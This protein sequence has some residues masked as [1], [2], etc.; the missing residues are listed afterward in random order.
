MASAGRYAG[1]A[2]TPMVPAS[3]IAENFYPH[4]PVEDSIEAYR[5]AE[6]LAVAMVKASNKISWRH[7]AF[8]VPL[9]TLQAE[10]VDEVVASN[11]FFRYI[12]IVGCARSLPP[13]GFLLP[14]FGMRNVSSDD[15]RLFDY[16]FVNS[17][18]WMFSGNVTNMLYRLDERSEVKR[19]E[20]EG[21]T[22][23]ESRAVTVSIVVNHR[24]GI[25]HFAPLLAGTVETWFKSPATGK[26]FGS[27]PASRRVLVVYHMGDCVAT[28]QKGRD[29][30]R[31]LLKRVHGA[32]FL[33]VDRDGKF[34]DPDPDVLGPHVYVITIYEAQD[35]RR[36]EMPMVMDN[37]IQTDAVFR[38]LYSIVPRE[39][40]QLDLVLA[41]LEGYRAMGTEGDIWSV[42]EAG[43]PELVREFAGT[44]GPLPILGRLKEERIA[45]GRR[46]R[47]EKQE[48]LQRREEEEE[49]A[50][51]RHAGVSYA[52]DD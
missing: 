42:P 16:A 34:D 6:H 30:A 10:D 44:L 14:P 31:G 51:R 27:V 35:Y 48:E 15:G 43:I 37:V 39:K 50:R 19:P 23:G 38:L 3:P 52:D 24:V 2:P 21:K 36:V 28:V 13:M 33:F 47:K 17:Q 4:A 22:L 7:I 46:V 41:A 18:R 49:R 12:R 1:F 5:S 45:A 32:Q 20:A 9:F 11:A 26:E 8:S 29:E 40:R 25:L